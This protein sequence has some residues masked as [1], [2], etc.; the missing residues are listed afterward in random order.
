MDRF[1]PYRC[2]LPATSAAAAFAALTLVAVPA[3]LRGVAA[4]PAAAAQGQPVLKVNEKATTPMNWKLVWSDE[5]DRDG[6]PDPNKWGYEEGYIR[7]N[8]RQYYTRARKENAR[9][10]KG[11][12]II[13][14]RKEK[15]PNARHTPG[16]DDWKRAEFAEYT[17]ASLTTRGKGEWTYGR[18]E[19]R[20]KL[21]TGRGMWPAI[22]MLGTNISEVGWPRCGE[23][24][25]MEN[26]GFDPDVI[27]ANVHTQAYN[28]VKKTNKGNSIKV[29][30]PHAD[31]HVY[32]MDWTPEQVE[33]FVDGK[34]YFS[35]ANEKTGKD[36]WPFDAP[37]YLI[38]N[39]AIGGGWGGM[40]GIDDSI[41]PQ[42]YEID[43]V[44]VY[45][46]QK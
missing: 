28:H 21:P 3:V 7:N 23:L 6:M 5:F 22:W 19:V 11:V 37:H 42:R 8:E 34:K 16:S 10:E 20:A 39:S 43:Y 29:E 17:S 32:S 26:V 13:E 45:Q 15:F 25:I 44:R 12:L 33:F 14:S 2:R 24:D 4:S 46:Q 30:K 38:L 36:M 40:R 35:F 1:H 18:M 31:F 27:H 41:F 9:V